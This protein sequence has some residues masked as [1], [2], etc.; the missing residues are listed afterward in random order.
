MGK[1]NE[2][3]TIFVVEDDAGLSHLV[4][5]R[6]LREGYKVETAV[7]GEEAISWLKSN[8]ADLM[9]LDYKLLDMTGKKLVKLLRKNIILTPFIMVTGQGDEKLAVEMM[10]EGSRDYIMKEGA[11][12]E[13]LPT[14]IAQVIR[15]LEQEAKLIE[16]QNTLRDS[17]ARYRGMFDSA[18]DA[19]FVVD[20]DG[21]IIDA[22]PQ[23]TRIFGYTS[24]EFYDLKI[25]D[26]IHIDHQKRYEK[27][28]RAIQEQGEFQIETIGTQKD[29]TTIDVEIRGA[30]FEYKGQ[31]NFIIVF[32]DI[33][34]RKW[35]EEEI[36]LTNQQ[37]RISERALR[38]RESRLRAIF[39]GAAIG[40]S[41]VDLRGRALESNETLQEML[42]YSRAELRQKEFP[43]FVYPEDRQGSSRMFEDLANGRCNRYQM[44]LRLSGSDQRVVWGRLI[45]SLVRGTDG[46]PNY[47]IIMIEEITDHKKNEIELSESESRFRLLSEAA[48]EG[49]LIH[50]KGTI[51]DI[52]SAFSVMFGYDREE[53]IGTDSLKLI[54][55]DHRQLVAK[56]IRQ[57]YVEA[58]YEAKGIRKDDSEIFIIISAR[59]MPFH[60]RK[61][62]VATIR[63]ITE[64]KRAQDALQESEAKYRR[65]FE[66][67][68]NGFAYHRIILDDNHQPIDYEF[69]EINDAFEKITGTKRNDVI[70]NRFS[71]IFP[72]MKDS[73]HDWIENFGE[74][75]LTGNEVAFERYIEEYDRW[76]Y[77]S[78]YSPKKGFFATVFY[79]VTERRMLAEELRTFAT[80]LER[81][82]RELDQFAEVISSDLKKYLND[83]QNSCENLQNSYCRNLDPNGISLLEKIHSGAGNMQKVID[84]IQVYSRVETRGKPFAEVD[85]N[86]VAGKIM[87]NLSEVI[88]SSGGCLE[89][90]PLPTVWADKEQLDQLLEHLISN[91]F[92]FRSN[93]PPQ[94]EIEAVEKDNV[95]QITVQDNGIGIASEDQGRIF[96]MF[97]RLHSKQEYPGNGIGL[98]LCQKV[99]E[100]HGGRIWVESTPGAGSKFYFTLPTK[101]HHS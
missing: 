95:W 24:A 29:R 26:L 28:R 17:E 81:S 47:I 83:I 33:S 64:Q 31:K 37:L 88:K 75:A 44:E 98:S 62:R 9:L 93:V 66:K 36:R 94:V 23:A 12:L 72:R 99:I 97:R 40:M 69:L 63:D 55:P 82:N 10:K 49:I 96:N 61:V 58:P 70:G 11:F 78:A 91:A 50:E 84:E 6:L 42:G 59:M 20:F 71:Q 57:E 56:N 60:G 13:L 52:N 74:V 27:H 79:D 38:E 2:K 101:L 25:P 16:A 1:E 89:I 68:L 34:E 51:L 87:N 45:A 85:L 22:N 100:R 76:F 3:Y 77:F 7:S 30:L 73:G 90:S 80:D 39:Q 4:Q 19:V 43:E 86:Q 15:Q 5:R 92:K 32:R 18:L 14:V 67:M 46:E 41:L 54:A 65:L 35:A 21:E 48:F 8:H 53:L